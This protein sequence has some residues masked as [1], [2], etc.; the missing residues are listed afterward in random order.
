MAAR[1]VWL[2]AN[3]LVAP[4]AVL[5]LT[6]TRKAAA[7]LGARIRVGSPNGGALGR[8]SLDTRAAAP[9]CSRPNRPCST[10]AA[11]A[12]RLVAEHAMRVGAEP[13]PRL[14]SPAVRWQLADSV[15]RRFTG[16][17]SDDIGRRRRSP[18]T[19]CSWPASWPIIW[20][21]PSRSIAFCDQRAAPHGRVA[22]GA[23]AAVRDPGELADLVTVPEASPRTDAAGARLPR[24]QGRARRRRLRRPDGAGGAASPRVPE[25]GRSS[26]TV[27]RRAARRVPGHRPRPDRDA[28]RAVRRRAPGHGGRRPVPVD[29]RL[30]RGQRRQHRPLRRTVPRTSTAAGGAFT[31]STSWRNDR[32]ILHAANEVARRCARPTRWPPSLRPGPTGRPTATWSWPGCPTVEDEAGWVAERMRT[33]WDA[34]AR[35]T[36]ASARPPCSSVGAPRSRCWP[37]AARGRPAGRDRRPRRAADARPRSSTSWRPCA[38]WPTTRAD[39]RCCGCSPARAGASARATWPR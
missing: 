2:V 23:T 7:E 4:G 11:Y 10:Y 24:R 35:P 25:V 32:A 17:L 13:S 3:E 37:R 26:G 9:S 15:V 6:F 38:C 16:P 36:G 18:I 21:P 1:V 5:G 34:A 28:H 29:L 12:G 33:A 14:I 20:S 22:A 27:P 8:D 19:S 39:L 31:L 30:A